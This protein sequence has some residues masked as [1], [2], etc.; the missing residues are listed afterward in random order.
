MGRK[1]NLGESFLSWAHNFH[2]PKS[3]GKSGEESA[4]KALLPKYPLPTR[5]NKK[6]AENNHQTQHHHQTPELSTEN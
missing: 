1:E 3:G 4:V 6:E 2:P 5:Q